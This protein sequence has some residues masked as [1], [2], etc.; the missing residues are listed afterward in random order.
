MIRHRPRE[1][2]QGRTLLSP[3]GGLIL[4]SPYY[5]LTKV[6]SLLRHNMLCHW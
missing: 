4:M 6:D 1:W 3:P 2:V 5:D